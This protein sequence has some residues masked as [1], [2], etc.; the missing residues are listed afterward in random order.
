MLHMGLVIVKYSKVIKKVSS[1]GCCSGFAGSSIFLPQPKVR[2]I[3][4]SKL[5]IVFL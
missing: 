4:I 3:S 5:S 2:L 1:P